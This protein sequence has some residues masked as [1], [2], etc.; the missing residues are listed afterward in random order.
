MLASMNEQIKILGEEK[1]I[2]L[3]EINKNKRELEDL[4]RL[5]AQKQDEIDSKDEVIAQIES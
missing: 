1:Q 5:L 2:T 3:D 4:K